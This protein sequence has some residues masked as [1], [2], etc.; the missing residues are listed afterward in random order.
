MVNSNR[1]VTT[2]IRVSVA[3]IKHD[4]QKQLGKERIYFI[5]KLVVHYLGR[6]GQELKSKTWKN[7]LKL[8]L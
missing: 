2:C 8:E 1:L 5:L 6:S 3:V 4:E 7:K